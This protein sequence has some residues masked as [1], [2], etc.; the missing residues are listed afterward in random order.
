MLRLST[1]K[2]FEGEVADGRQP[3]NQKGGLNVL[4]NPPAVKAQW[5]GESD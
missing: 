1:I 2:R 5:F 3:P 4:A